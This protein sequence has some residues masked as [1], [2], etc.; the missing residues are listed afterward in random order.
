M[1]PET[2]LRYLEH[3]TGRFPREALQATIAQRDEITP[4]L[5]AILDDGVWDIDRIL[6]T[7]NSLPCAIMPDG[8]RYG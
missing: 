6:R 5:L 1:N 2:I 8:T 4:Y 3:N 7:A